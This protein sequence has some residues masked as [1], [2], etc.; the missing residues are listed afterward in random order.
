MDPQ[1]V[2][3]PALLPSDSEKSS[4]SPASLPIEE[5]LPSAQVAGPEFPMLRY[6]PFLLGIVWF[7]V[8]GSSRAFSAP[9][10]PVPS[11]LPALVAVPTQPSTAAVAE[12]LTSFDPAAVQLQ[13]RDHRWVI[14]VGDVVLKDFGRREAEARQ[15]L[16]LI[17]DLG[18][19]QRGTAGRPAPVMEYW[20]A[21][22]RSPMAIAPGLPLLPIDLASLR[23][24]QIQAQW[25][26]R[27]DLRVLFNFGLH[28]DEAR[29][30]LAIVRKYRFGQIG[31]LGQ[32]YPSM[33]VFLGTPEGDGD[34]PLAPSRVHKT[35]ARQATAAANRPPDRFPGSVVSTALPAL[36]EGDSGLRPAHVIPP[37][38]P[39]SSRGSRRTA[40]PP[41]WETGEDLVPF[42]WR[43]V[44]VRQQEG[45][46][47][48]IVGGHVL[49]AFGADEPAAQQALAVVRHYHLTE[50]CLVGRP[51]PLFSYFLAAGQPPRGLMF[52]LAGGAFQPDRLTVEQLGR[53]WALCEGD[54][55][56]VDLGEQAEEARD[57]LETIRRYQ[58]DRLVWIG[59][60]DTGMSLLLRVH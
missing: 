21:A 23:V 20:L 33:M 35:S 32:N 2:I 5:A 22:G 45:T 15:A 4:F 58:F 16:R 13:W 51:R 47:Q 6:W 31:V 19:T 55:V 44:Q 48:L 26:L 39:S 17:R 46:W 41:G 30:A 57:L 36:H 7:A 60:R 11:A 52:G 54:R 34:A 10:Q 49:A 1:S 53:Q 24:E 43:Q 28:P 56:L 59:P 38:E 27:D 3:R 18:L 14:L 12:D 8:A 25:C 50:Q 37:G 29:R 42:D 9:S 40:L